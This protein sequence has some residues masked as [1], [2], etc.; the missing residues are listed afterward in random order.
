MEHLKSIVF[1]YVTAF[2]VRGRKSISGGENSIWSKNH[3]ERKYEENVWNRRYVLMEED[4][5]DFVLVTVYH[6]ID[7]NFLL[8]T[9]PFNVCFCEGAVV[10][11]LKLCD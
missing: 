8:P 1:F 2:Y 6:L 5:Y 11:K 7:I 4:L 3:G 9:S 10:L